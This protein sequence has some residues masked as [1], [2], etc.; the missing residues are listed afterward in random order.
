MKHYLD[1]A[2]T[3]KVAIEMTNIPAH[4]DQLEKVFLFNIT[5]S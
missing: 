5:F 2:T 4:L 3:S 1:V